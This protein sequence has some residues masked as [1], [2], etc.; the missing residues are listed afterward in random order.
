M[1]ITNAF[2]VDKIVHVG[3][4]PDDISHMFPTL[5]TYVYAQYLSA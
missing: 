4:S 1:E 3:Y 2:S 5:I